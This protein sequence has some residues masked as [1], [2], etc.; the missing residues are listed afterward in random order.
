MVSPCSSDPASVKYQTTLLGV[1]ECR[2]DACYTLARAGRQ[3]ECQTCHGIS[4]TRESGPRGTRYRRSPSAASFTSRRDQDGTSRDLALR[5]AICLSSTYAAV[6]PRSPTHHG[7]RTVAHVWQR[8]CAHAIDRGWPVRSAR[9]L[10]SRPVRSNFQVPTSNSEVSVR[11]AGIM[12][13]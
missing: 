12:N 1:R 5:R 6:M 10:C 3:P 2:L 11:E 4:Q 8:G 7:P 13:S 9:C